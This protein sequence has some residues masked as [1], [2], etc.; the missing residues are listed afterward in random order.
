MS[1]GI[2][3]Q[4]IVDYKKI[5]GEV[6]R[7]LDPSVAALIEN[8]DELRNGPTIGHRIRALCRANLFDED[9]CKRIDQ[10]ILLP[11]DAQKRIIFAILLSKALKK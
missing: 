8:L 3:Y 9:V 5:I 10:I 7:G 11:E 4:G 1:E 2:N 6:L